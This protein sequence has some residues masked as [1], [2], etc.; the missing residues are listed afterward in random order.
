MRR[1][2]LVVLAAV[3]LSHCDGEDVRASRDWRNEGTEVDKVRG[4]NRQREFA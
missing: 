2:L 3:V 1:L 4:G